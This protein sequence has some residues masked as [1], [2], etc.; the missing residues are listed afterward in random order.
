MS[1]VLVIGDIHAPVTHPGYLAFCEDMAIK[2]KCDRIHFIGDVIDWHTVS[3]H[4]KHPDA[5]GTRDEYEAAMKA[6]RG[7]HKT[8]PKAT[9]SIGNHDERPRRLAESVN[10]CDTL[11][12]SYREMWHTPGWRWEYETIIDGIY[13]FHG[14]GF[15]GIHPAY[16]A[17]AKMCMSVVMGHVHTAGGVKWLVN[18]RMRIFGMDTGCGIDD[19]AAAMLYGRHL[20]RKSVISCG[21]VIDRHP[22]HLMMP[23]ARG[24]KYHRSRFAPAGGTRRKA[25]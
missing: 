22:Y 24:E 19:R 15:G 4:A 14:I 5:P 25:A 8:F 9:V 10:I 16:N 21:V 20:K 12:K 11:I 2:W 7:W 18:P 13:Y 23:L 17:M 1:R 3:V 6:V